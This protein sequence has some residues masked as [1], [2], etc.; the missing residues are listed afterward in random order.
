MIIDSPL[1]AVAYSYEGAT[2]NTSISGILCT[3]V[4]TLVLALSENHAIWYG[5]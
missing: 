2:N 3:K 5:I 1:A 4:V